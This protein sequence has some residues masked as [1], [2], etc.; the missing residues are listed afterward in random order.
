M[1]KAYFAVAIVFLFLVGAV[2]CAR[3]FSQMPNEVAVA[4]AAFENYPGLTLSTPLPGESHEKYV[5]VFA[6]QHPKMPRPTYSH[7]FATWFVKQGD[8]VRDGFT[9]SW[10]GERNTLARQQGQNLSLE[11]T[12]RRAARQGL[13]VYRFGPYYCTDE[14]YERAK[15]HYQDIYRHDYKLID[16]L[17]RKEGAFNCIHAVALSSGQDVE[18]KLSYGKEASEKVVEAFVQR[19]LISGRREEPAWPVAKSYF[20]SR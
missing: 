2:V 10:Y 8:K 20:L 3:R 15:R 6:Y 9:I 11:E 14:F 13:T 19:R 4:G 17:T 1:N 5:V 18:T 7:S 16:Y 12:Y